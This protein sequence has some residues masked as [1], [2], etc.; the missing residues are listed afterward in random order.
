MQLAASE[1]FSRGVITRYPT[2]TTNLQV[3]SGRWSLAIYIYI[4]V[5]YS[6]HAVL[7]VTATKLFLIPIRTRTKAVQIPREGEYEYTNKL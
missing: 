3:Y 2:A 5:A 6:L 1:F 4:G 7:E